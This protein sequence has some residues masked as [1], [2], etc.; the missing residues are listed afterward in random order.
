MKY[1]ATYIGIVWL[2]F[3]SA[4]LGVAVYDQLTHPARYDIQGR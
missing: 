1:L 2:I 4:V 3:I